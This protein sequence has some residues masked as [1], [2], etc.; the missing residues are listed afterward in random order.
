MRAAPSRR[1]QHAR[2]AIWLAQP[3]V[4]FAWIIPFGVLALVSF[5]AIF[6]GLLFPA[7]PLH[8]ISATT[9]VMSALLMLTLATRSVLLRRGWMPVSQRDLTHTL[10]VAEQPYAIQEACLH[11]LRQQRWLTWAEVWAIKGRPTGMEVWFEG[12]SWRAGP[13]TFRRKVILRGPMDRPATLR[14]LQALLPLAVNR[15]ADAMLD[16]PTHVTRP[17]RR[18]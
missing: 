11:A 7:F 1:H 12:Q 14:H 15:Q 10:G 9:Q 2:L 3:P 6:V 18:S 13:F 8:W 4:L 16:V 5:L 17:R